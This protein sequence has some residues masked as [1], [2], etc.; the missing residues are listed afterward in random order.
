MPLASF[1]K[2]N[3]MKKTFTL[4]VL[5]LIC[6]CGY[7]QTIDPVLLQEIGR[8]GGDEKIKVFVIMKSQY[9]QQQLNR[10]AAHFTTRAE[11][12]EFVVNELK[13]FTEA[14]QYDLRHSLA[15]MQR[16]ELVSEPKELWI[17]NALCFEATRDAILSLSERTDIMVIGL[18]EERNWLPDGVETQPAEPT[19][20]ITSNVTQVNA[21]QVWNLGYTGQG[22]VVAVIDTGVNYNHLDLAD[23][24]W[25]GGT[26]FPNHGYDVYNT[27]NDPIDDHGH[28]THCAG[29]VCGD[30]TAGSQTGMAPDATLMCV[31]CLNSS[32]RC[33]DSHVVSSMQWAVEHGCDVISM[34]LGGHGHSGAE[35]TFLRN[36][37]VN[38]LTSGVIASISAGNEGDQMSQYP[39]PDNI[40]LPGGCPPPYLDPD[41]QLN[42]GGLSCSVCVGAVNSSDQAAAFSSQGPRDW[43]SS[44]Y[45]DYLLTP[46]SS[47]EFGLIRPDVCAPGVSIKSAYYGSN[48]GYTL[49]SGTSMAAPCVAGCM[50]LMLSKSPNTAPADLCRILEETAVPL[51]TGKSNIYGCG[52]VDVL[53][54]INAL[55][56]GP[57]ALDSYTIN[58]ESGNSNGQLN[59]GEAVTLDFTLV[60][61]EATGVD[62]VTIT[63]STE[64]DYVTITN[65]S[66]A[67]PHFNAGETKTI[68]DIFAFTLNDDTPVTRTIPFL[69]EI[70][71][72]GESSGN[73]YL[74]MMVYGHM[75]N[76]VDVTVLNDNNGNGSLEAG[77]TADLHV[78]INNSGNEDAYSVVGTLSSAFPYLT[79]NG[80]VET[81]G[82]VEVNGQASAD[83][84]VTL[85][86]NAPDSYTM[87][88]SLDLVDTYQK[89]SELEFELWRK[90][91]TLTSNPAGAGTL[92]G[93]GYYSHNQTCTI[94]AEP[95]EGYVFV[96]WTLE[97]TVV[98]YLST[99]SFT[100]ASEAEYVAN[101][102]TVTNGV[103][104]G[105]GTGTN[106]LLPSY[107]FYNYTLSQQI[108]TADELD[109][110][111]GEISSV[112]FFNTG[113]AKTRHYTIYMVNTDKTT[114]GN[115]YDW[116]TV[117]EADQVFSGSINM[118]AGSWTTLYFGTPF[119]YD[120]T[121]NIALIVDDNTGSWS[122]G[123]TCR[124]N[125]TNGS[126]AIYIYSDGTNYDPFNP[127]GYY[128]YRL[129]V[130]N[131]VIF[132]MPSY[133][134]TVTVSTNPAEGGTVS[135]GEGLYYYGQTCTLNAEANAG[136]SF[137]YWM[138]NGTIVSTEAHYSFPVTGNRNL[139]AVFGVPLNIT[140]SANLVEGGFL[141]G[142]GVFD[143]GATCT[144]KATPYVGYRFVN[145]TKNGTM[146][147]TDPT[148][149]FTVTE[150]A[151]FMANFTA[152][153]QSLQVV[154]QY[155][156]DATNSNSQFVKVSWA[157]STSSALDSGTSSDRSTY[158]IYRANCDGSG[159]QMIA[160]N[161]T[162]SQYIDAEWAELPPGNYAYGVGL[163]DSRGQGS[164]IHWN[165]NAV[166]ANNQVIDLSDYA[167]PMANIG[168]P[169]IPSRMNYD[170]GWLYYD[171][172][173]IYTNVGTFSSTMYWGIMIPAANLLPNAGY[174]L[175]KVALYTSFS[176][177]TTLNIYLGGDTAPAGDPIVVQDFDMLGNRS[178][179]EID[180]NNPVPIDGTQNLWITFYNQTTSFPAAACAYM[181]EPNG[182]W[183]SSDGSYWYHSSSYTW[184]IR[185]FV[186]DTG[187][188]ISWSNRIGKP[189]VLNEGW[190]WWSTYI[191]LNGRD[192]IALLEEA[193]GDNGLTIATFDDAAINLGGMWFGLE[194][195]TV[196]N[197][198][199]I[200]IEVAEDCSFTLE[201]PAV[202]PSTITIPINPG[203]NWIGFPVANETNINDA[204]A[205]FTAEFEDQIASFTG[206]TVNFGDWIGD[207]MTLV[208]GQ[209]Y[210]YY[211]IST[212][213]KTL[214]FQNGVKARRAY[215]NFG[216]INKQPIEVEPT[217]DKPTH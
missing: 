214:I 217:E 78:V 59:P 184:M 37:C 126:Q 6:I 109:L 211:S 58:D 69:A 159:Q 9:D 108:Y 45:A 146:V 168:N 38:V 79:I 134:Y 208:P 34:S 136:Y 25:D 52:R 187:D 164:E 121:S 209:G 74:N 142:A 192:G 10:R 22:V 84:N 83:F 141:S 189:F 66:F 163:M 42:P 95:N 216:R 174:N 107:S 204:L 200:M 162:G 183:L 165:K 35:Q 43:S 154:A 213:P 170:D 132:G 89:H 147:S 194:G 130:K 31:K 102:Q 11:R 87:V 4:I 41:Q 111:A 155:Y 53:A 195:Y 67:L 167:S 40:G 161:I 105:N 117:T 158:C 51:S 103:V 8:R 185:G 54:A 127:S 181:G 72:N 173:T 166:A 137:Y 210:M 122:S 133:E 180:L 85:A 75:L 116:I 93:E 16:N 88:F 76:F 149:S 123:M 160:E 199:M 19:R 60:N 15:E 71:I 62:G 206:A 124:V 191:D 106:S 18:D 46:G 73:I 17:A 207:F 215:P 80:N 97:G 33:N 57:L 21:D 143:Y 115:S 140:V 144:L 119:A 157:S 48:N 100:V 23:H 110:E 201:G 205:G 50:A 156:P 212:T 77:E 70:F 49:K 92:S 7:A 29:T 197:S 151:D 3:D 13:R 171:N 198:E 32:G 55:Y 203:W 86:N 98:S 139:V 14:S 20:E 82:T 138:E 150:D 131:Q 2:H 28:G 172:G 96:S 196:S 56:A 135:G 30:G 90:A 36:T 24:L 152:L 63:L 179:M 190:N 129:S 12:R 47:T 68:E 178:F 120:G 125:N 176:G 27:D 1:L 188:A 113:T 177:T 193:L 81:F 39:I 186:E 99:Y 112:S 104:I 101:F 91:I 153:S 118:T 94:T 145:W 5:A 44:D 64:S 61:E 202:D 128:G 65:G 182:S 175:T 169:N 148:Y 114:F 26:E